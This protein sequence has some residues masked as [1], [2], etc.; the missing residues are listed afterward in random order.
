MVPRGRERW[1]SILSSRRALAAHGTAAL[2]GTVAWEQTGA[3]LVCMPVPTL[4]WPL[5]RGAEN[6][7]V[8]FRAEP[9]L[10]TDAHDSRERGVV[11]ISNCVGMSARERLR[12]FWNE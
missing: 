3:G 1:P 6:M 7:V 5:P 9:A 12:L 2:A 10:A 4:L 8:R 11:V